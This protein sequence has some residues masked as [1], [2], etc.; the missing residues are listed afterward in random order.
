MR[1]SR[2]VQAV[3][4]KSLGHGDQNQRF[5]HPQPPS[6]FGGGGGGRSLLLFIKGPT[7]GG[8]LLLLKSM[9]SAVPS[10]PAPSASS[11]PSQSLLFSDLGNWIV[12]IS[13]VVVGHIRVVILVILCSQDRKSTRLNSSHLG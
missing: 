6:F 11:P 7:F 3:T 9:K 5:E 12:T 10:A 4:S 2:S 8:F 13:K 1:P